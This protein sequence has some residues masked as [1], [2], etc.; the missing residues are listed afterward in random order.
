MEIN[1]PAFINGESI[2]KKYTCQ[3]EDISPALFFDG[4]PKGTKSLALIV[5]DPDAPRGTFVHWIGWNIA[6][7]EHSFEEGK[8]LPFEGKNSF[9]LKGYKGPCPPPGNSHR[10]FFKLYALDI[11]VDLPP[12]SAKDELEAVMKGHVL[13]HAELVGTYKR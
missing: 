11:R 12:G 8:P 2:P 7:E 6:P 4:I 13:D 1:S 9:G 3:G 10:Y 5:D